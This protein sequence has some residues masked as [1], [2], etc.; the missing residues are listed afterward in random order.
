PFL[1]LF[2]LG[3]GGPVP[4]VPSLAREYFGR[5]KLGTIIGIIQGS[6]SVCNMVGPSLAGWI[7]DHFGTYQIAWYALSGA[8]FFGIVSMLSAPSVEKFRREAPVM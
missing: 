7:Y 3:Y 1:I 6:F 8:M 5:A 2:G 4:M